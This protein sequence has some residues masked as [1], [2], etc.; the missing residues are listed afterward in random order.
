MRVARQLLTGG[1]LLG[2]G[3]GAT[4]LTSGCSDE[5]K[6]SGTHVVIDEVEKQQMQGEK[7]ATEA[8]V[9]ARR[10]ANKSARRGGR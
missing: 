6:T 3:F 5:S 4:L 8:A 2:L 1:F 9:A 7:E 10:A